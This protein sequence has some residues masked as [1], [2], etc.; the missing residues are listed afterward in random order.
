MSADCVHRNYASR[1]AE[2]GAQ[3]GYWHFDDVLGGPDLLLRDA[4]PLG[5]AHVEPDFA[6]V[7]RERRPDAAEV[8]KPVMENLT[9]GHFGEP[10]VGCRDPVKPTDARARV[11]PEHDLAPLSHFEDLHAVRHPL[12]RSHVDQYTDAVLVEPEA[13]RVAQEPARQVLGKGTRPALGAAISVLWTQGQFE[14]WAPVVI[15]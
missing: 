3:T 2:I 10:V 11:E 15:L 12:A 6:R 13:G 7:V 1:S 9:T 8:A 14:A 5:R 4:L